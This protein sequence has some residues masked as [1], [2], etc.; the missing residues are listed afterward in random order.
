MNG[1]GQSL[2]G[3]MMKKQTFPDVI[4][5]SSLL[6][7]I[8]YPERGFRNFLGCFD[9]ILSFYLNISHDTLI[10]YIFN[11]FTCNSNIEF[12]KASSNQGSIPIADCCGTRI[13]NTFNIA[14][15]L[16]QLIP[17]HLLVT[18]FF[19]VNFKIFYPY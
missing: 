18:Y 6:S 8:G 9:Q 2:N 17:F 14:P 3:N 7:Q 4:P 1:T 15:N 12:E 11:P 5:I 10:L 13:F 16:S 19:L